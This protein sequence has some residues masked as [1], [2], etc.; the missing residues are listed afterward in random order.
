MSSGERPGEQPSS[1]AARLQPEDRAFDGADGRLAPAG[2]ANEQVSGELEP[3]WEDA[4]ERIDRDLGEALADLHDGGFSADE[5]GAEGAVRRLDRIARD[6]AHIEMLRA[7]RFAGPHY[8]LFKTTLALYGYPVMRAWLRRRQIWGLTAA[9]GRGVACRD[10]VRDHLARDLDDRQELAMEV[11]AKALVFFRKHALL[12]GR[13]TPDGGANIT[14]FF[15]GACVAVFPNVFRAWLKEHEM[16]QG[17]ERLD[18]GEWDHLLDPGTGAGPEE[19]ACLVDLFETA[20]NAAKTGR[21][22]RALASVVLVD[23]SYA[24]IA[25]AEGTSQEA[26][27]QLVYRFRLSGEGRSS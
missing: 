13:W 14:T 16:D 24:E 3:N 8:E 20:L 19:H 23:A 2:T 21:L 11:V 18:L 25:E 7:E 12:A 22:R 15:A 4:D 26:I 6:H 5:S 1:C 27:K 9:R 10:A 17:C